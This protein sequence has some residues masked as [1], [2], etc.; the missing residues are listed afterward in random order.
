MLKNRILSVLTAFILSSFAAES[1]QAEVF[2]WKDPEFKIDFVFPH[3]WR[4]QHD[5]NTD[6]RIRVLAPQG[7]DYA[8]CKISAKRDGRYAMYPD[9]YV[10]R[11]NS[12]VFDVKG[13]M[14]YWIEHDNVR[15]IHRSDYASIGKSH[16]VYAEARYTRNFGIRNLPMRGMVLAT[17]YGDMNLVF[18]CEAAERNWNYWVPEFMSMARTVNF[19]LNQRSTPNGW[20][21][22]FQEDGEIYMSTDNA[23]TGTITY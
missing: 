16:A 14:Q 15:M 6:V 12:V 2:Y 5:K 3:E 11:V 1:A 20:Y 17:L 13:L 8:S 21:R 7:Q 10:Q 19:P 4:I 18:D 22:R 23:R 9:R